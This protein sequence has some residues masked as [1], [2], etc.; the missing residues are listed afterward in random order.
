[1]SIHYDLIDG[2]G[3]L[4]SPRTFITP[5]K[6]FKI[7]LPNEG[8]SLSTDGTLILSA[9]YTWDFGSWAIDTPDMVEASALHDAICILTNKRML[10]WRYRAVGDRL[11]RELLQSHQTHRKWYNP[12]KHW[13]WVRWAGVSAYSQLIARWRDRR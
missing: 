4:K 2:I 8:I 11:F 9:G 10:P 1:M 5:I 7:S 13:P 6:Q 12:L 3:V